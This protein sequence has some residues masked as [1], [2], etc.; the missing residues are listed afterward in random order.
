MGNRSSVWTV[1]KSRRAWR[2]PVSEHLSKGDTSTH[3]LGG[4]RYI[5]PYCSVPGQVYPDSATAI[6]RKEPYVLL[7]HSHYIFVRVIGSYLYTE[8]IL[9]SS[10]VFHSL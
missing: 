7:R 2:N 3:A 6:Q 4:F 8:S 5:Q 10:I 1:L 9:A